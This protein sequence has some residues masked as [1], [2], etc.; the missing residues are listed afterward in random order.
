MKKITLLAFAILSFFT[1]Q[2]EQKA[3]KW[4]K[5]A[6]PA[7]VSVDTYDAA[8]KKLRTGTAVVTSIDGEAL[9]DYALFNGAARAEVTTSK[10]EKHAVSAIIG[11]NDLYDVIKIK[12]DFPKKAPF[13]SLVTNKPVANASVVMLP[14]STAK[15]ASFLTGTVQ[16]VT[17]LVDTYSYYQL[18]LPLITTQ[19]SAPIFTEEG[20]L[21][22]LAQADAAGSTTRSYA[23]SAPYINSL[24][25]SASDIFNK[26]YTGIGIKKAWPASVDDALVMLFVLSG[27][28]KP[29]EKLA[30]LNDFIASFPQSAE[31]YTNR[32]SH[33]A[34][35]RKALMEGG[36]SEEALLSKAKEDFETALTK[37]E[38]KSEVYYNQANLIYN[39]AVSDTLLQS[40]D[41]SVDAA[42]AVLEEAISVDPKPQYTLLKGDITF[43]QQRYEEALAL[44][45][46]V[47]ATEGATHTSYYLAAKA[48]EQLPNANVGEIIAL[49]DSAVV[50]S[51]SHFKKE[52]AHYV[53]ERVALKTDLGLYKEIVADYDLYYTLVNGEV[54]DV[55]YYYREQAKFRLGDLQGAMQDI[56]EALNLSPKDATYLAEKAAIQVRLKEY[57]A[58][59]KSIDAALAIDPKFAACYRLR[60]VC[61]IRLKQ[62]TQVCEALTQAI[63]L[64]DPVA[65]KLKK[66]H[67]K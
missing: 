29:T 14:Y 23:I 39:V 66:Q 45:E 18:N 37:A 5:K 63:E 30:T 25:I 22:G 42:L 26:T 44:Y 53:L 55:F 31:G 59:L 9:S 56:N 62:M 4:V 51:G 52:A 43:Y 8:G 60:A 48:K 32:A 16:E 7:V 2:A 50:R 35:A 11:A 19:L 36:E 65:E 13:V 10:G 47:N 57:D 67:C 21:V 1:L 34:Y 6:A 46:A 64:G 33:Y 15:E 54:A 38:D 28:Q 41:W 49:L 12:I 58:A 17:P 40:S 24:R 61:Y 3:P 27:T 20:E